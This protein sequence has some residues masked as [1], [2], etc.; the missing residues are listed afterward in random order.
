MCKG[1]F[2]SDKLILPEKEVQH[3]YI[4]VGKNIYIGGNNLN[5]CVRDVKN[6]PKKLISTFNQDI[7]CLV[8]TDG[9]ATV[10]NYK[11]IVARAVSLL[12]PGATVVIPADC[13]FSGTN[14]RHFD[15]SK[16]PTK[17]RYIDP[18]LPPVEKVRT[19][20][21]TAGDLNWIAMSGCGEHQTS[22]DAY[23]NGNYVGAYSFYGDLVMRKGMT[24]LEWNEAIRKYLPGNGFDQAPEIEGPD[25]LLNRKLFEGQT[26]WIHNSS[27]GSWTYDRNG[28]EADGRDEG[29][30]FDYL[31]IDDQIN[32]L[33]QMIPKAA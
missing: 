2:K 32:E 4:G 6:R 19:K 7:D 18:G 26:L 20:I 25:F 8:Y 28:D 9:Q 31:L 23:I 27:H 16:H 10:E 30:Y 15:S 11:K 33:L 24:Y 1:W 14:T 21:F 13:C 3:R 17:N 29:I 5:G 12:S 22:A